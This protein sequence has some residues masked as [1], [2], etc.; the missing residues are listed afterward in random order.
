PEGEL[1]YMS[2]SCETITGYPPQAFQDDPGLLV[3][4]VHPKDREHFAAHAALEHLNGAPCSME[5]RILTK[6]GEERWLQHECQPVSGQDGEHLGRRVSNRDAT[7]RKRLDAM[8]EDVERVIRH[9]L[10]APATSVIG[11]CRALRD[12]GLDEDQ[13][14]LVGLLEESAE[15]MLDLLDMTLDI[16]RMETGA[17]ALRPERVDLTELAHRVFREAQ[18]AVRPGPAGYRLVRNGAGRTPEDG[19]GAS[20]AVWGEPRLLHS[21]LANLVLN[22]AQASPEEGEVTVRL[23]RD[24]DA[25]LVSVCN[26]GAVPAPMRERFFEKYATY[27]KRT[28]IGLGTYSARLVTE[29]HG[30]QIRMRTSDSE[31]T[32]VD[33]RLPRSGPGPAEC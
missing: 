7:Q 2:P 21:L 8:R 10:R 30:G 17:Y 3:A 27:G 28:G 29:L 1:R 18:A 25:D 16:F 31:G 24:G 5:F 14:E 32:R 12:D 15:R 22:A 9:D 13:D 23:G 19:D 4:V 6:G 20:F 26:Q 11:A 33:V